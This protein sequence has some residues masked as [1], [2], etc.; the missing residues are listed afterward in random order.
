MKESDPVESRIAFFFWRTLLITVQA[1]VGQSGWQAERASRAVRS[2]WPCLR[3][4]D[5]LPLR[6]TRRGRLASA[7]AGPTLKPPTTGARAHRDAGRT[8]GIVPIP[9][10]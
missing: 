6:R 1:N 4:V 2:R 3:T 8:R 7:D 9:A 5:R 10:A